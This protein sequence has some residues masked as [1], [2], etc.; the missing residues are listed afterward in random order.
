MSGRELLEVASKRRHALLRT[1]STNKGLPCPTHKWS[2][3]RVYFD[4]NPRSCENSASK[5]AL[6]GKLE[7]GLLV[8]V[9]APATFFGCIHSY[10][11]GQPP[12][13]LV[14]VPTSIL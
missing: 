4:Q 8:I 10:V 14:T 2:T 9:T 11:A 3:T 13:H 7:R 5:Q 12:N 6:V 1:A